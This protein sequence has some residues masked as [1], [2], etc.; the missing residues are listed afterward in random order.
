M[1]KPY[2]TVEQQADGLRVVDHASK[3]AA[4]A[5]G[6]SLRREGRVVFAYSVET[7]AKHGM[8]PRAC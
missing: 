7:A 3:K 2:V 8:D 1:S 4:H 6:V 5:F